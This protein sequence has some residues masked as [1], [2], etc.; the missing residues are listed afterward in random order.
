V[1]PVMVWLALAAD[2]VA[3]TLVGIEFRAG[4]SSLLPMLA[5]AR[6]CGIANQ[7]YFQISFQLSERP[8][9]LAAQSFLTLF[10]SVVLMFPLVA[11]SGVFGAALATLLTEA[12]GLLVA[13]VLMRRAYRLPFDINRLAGVAASAAVMAVA[14]L[15]VRSVV[16]GTG[17]FAL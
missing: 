16:L 8:F 4:V 1:L 15:V 11:A 7:F 12:I 10:V 5:V 2:Q 17:L 3:G 6:L 9:L 13:I 14:I